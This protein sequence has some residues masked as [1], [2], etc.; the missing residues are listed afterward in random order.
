VGTEAGDLHSQ[1]GE[2]AQPGFEAKS[3]KSPCHPEDPEEDGIQT[4]RASVLQ[5]LLIDARIA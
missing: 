2:S 5:S 3:R 4:T 1:A